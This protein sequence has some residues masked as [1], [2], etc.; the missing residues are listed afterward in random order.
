MSRNRVFSEFNHNHNFKTTPYTPDEFMSQ[1]DD[2]A[3]RLSNKLGILKEISLT[4]GEEVRY[5]NKM[6]QETDDTFT[7]TKDYLGA[8]MNKL[9]IL[10]KSE[11]D[12]LRRNFSGKL[13]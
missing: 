10:S 4:I 3:G 9:K 6:L 2:H 12:K 11:N 8:T 13:Q 5:H 7:K 1:N